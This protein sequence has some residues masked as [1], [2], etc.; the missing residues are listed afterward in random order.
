MNEFEQKIKELAEK[1][2]ESQKFIYKLEESIDKLPQ[3]KKGNF[4][5]EVGSTLF[6]FS[7]FILALDSWN[8][9]LKH[10]IEIEDRDGE[11]I[12]YG[13]L[14]NTYSRLG[15]F[16]KA[17]EY[18]ER[19]LK[20]KKDIGDRAGESACYTNLGNVYFRLGDFRKAIEYYERSLKIKKHIED[21][22]GELNCY[23]G[24]GNVYFSLGDFRKA[25]EYHE[26]SLKI[27]KDI[28]DR[29]VVSACYTN[30][31]NVY[32]RLGDFR[33]AIEY[34]E[35]SLK[36][37]K[38]IGDRAGESACYTNLGNTYN[39]LGDF[40]KAIEYHEKSL[41]IA[42]D[43]VDRI[44]ESACYTNL[45]ATYSSLG[46]FRKAI[47]YHKTSL[48]IAKD[49]GDRA[50]ES[51]CYGNL[52]NTYNRLEDFRKAIEYHERSLK[53]KKDIGDRDGESVCY[54]NLGNTY[55][56][57]G[58]F[59]KAIEYYERSLKIAKH[60]E[61]RIVESVC[62][63]NLGNA[64]SS[65]GDFRKAIE[66][67][68]RSLKIA[69][70]IKDRAGESAC[71]TNLGNTYNRL[72]D[73]KKAIEYHERS[74]RIIK[75]TGT[76]DFERLVNLNLG[77]TYY[78]HN[79]Q[80][81]FNYLKCSIELS[82]MIGKGL[83][84]EEHKIGFYGLAANAYQSMI[85]LC[86]KLDKDEE[87][88][89]YTQ[90]SKSK[91]FLDMLAATYVKP[92]NNLIERDTLLQ[93]EERCLE[94]I[95]EL[96]M[97]YLYKS[98]SPIKLGE[99][100]LI[101]ENL[102]EIYNEMEKVDQEYVFMRQARTLSLGKIEEMLSSEK[103]NTVI[104]EYFTTKDKLFIFVVSKNGLHVEH[105]SISGEKL[106]GYINAY[107]KEVTVSRGAIGN[108]WLELSNYLIEP[109]SEYLVKSDLIYFIPY[110]ALH[111][112][113]IHALKLGGEPLIKSYPICY[114]PAVSIIQFCKNKGSDKLEGCA[115]FGIVFENEA[116]EVA[117]LFNTNPYLGKTANKKNVIE[118]ANKDII[119]L[120]CHGY[121]DNLDP[122]SSGVLL[123]NEEI[124]TAREIFNM[125]I[126]AELVTLSACQTGIN[127]R[128]PGD[129]LIGLTRAFLYAGTSSVVV[130]L[131]SVDPQSTQELMVEF[132]KLLKK[133]RDKATALQKAQK[134]IM[135]KEKYSHPYYWAP[136]ILVGDWE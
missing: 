17:I 134:E 62:Y 52:G 19:S 129:E 88:F 125:K 27:A 90:R 101:R 131:W 36:I 60:I 75:K 111:Y 40:K 5:L 12:C 25:I 89:H 74:L 132:Y 97:S 73:F 105:V 29:I 118:C 16:R 95:R 72:G 35:R 49:I 77:L 85:P 53:I 51:A 99:V 44:V 20:I 102:N 56:R 104:V 100:D 37:A 115:S 69:K 3:N 54:G 2:K 63:R 11:S 32:F 1:Y 124:L 34:H 113:P 24:L 28:V 114:S 64:Y 120:S 30:L 68:E 18:H 109:I 110:G 66:Y 55:N 78:D 9:A 91:T 6:K 119:H 126:N 136:F 23:T 14:G 98:V 39:R 50:G 128:K 26:R 48:K 57:L 94:R 84:E 107:M 112:I 133:G 116:E 79:P 7:Y 93:D 10:F 121:F 13:N 33:K 92:S 80:L 96:Q 38:D 70:D 45:G 76:K 127:K 71:Y 31:G 65:L 87:A 106:F 22:Y 81:A 130:S 15:D 122:L 21:R 46:D 117:K 135:K 43:I 8:H 103:R 42:K 67:Y 4:F 47:E 123:H 86:L 108:T 58:D 59:R 82:E 61:D 41:K 83:I